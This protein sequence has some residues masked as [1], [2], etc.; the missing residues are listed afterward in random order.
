MLQL[1]VR[2]AGIGYTN[3]RFHAGVAARAYV[4]CQ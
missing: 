1:A 3:R 2:V 4:D